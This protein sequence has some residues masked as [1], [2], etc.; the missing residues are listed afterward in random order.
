M[1]SRIYIVALAVCIS[2]V[3]FPASAAAK[4]YSV[5]LNATGKQQTWVS[6]Q[7]LPDYLPL[8]FTIWA[9]GRELK[10]GRSEDRCRFTLFSRRLALEVNGCARTAGSS[11]FD[12][13]SAMS[14]RYIG[15]TRFRIVYWAG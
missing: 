14:V 10:N 8:S 13:R 12:A 11:K 2:I 5:S 3:A 4:K 15:S 1:P 6:K 9:N 7:K